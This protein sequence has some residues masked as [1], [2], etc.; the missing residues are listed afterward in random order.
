VERGGEKQEG[1]RGRLCIS[2][3]KFSRRIRILVW[4]RGVEAKGADWVG[5]HLIYTLRKV[6]DKMRR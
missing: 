1:R 5:F 4:T 6:G 3:T 2:S